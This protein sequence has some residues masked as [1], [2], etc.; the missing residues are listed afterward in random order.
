MSCTMLLKKVIPFV[1]VA[2]FLVACAPVFASTDSIYTQDITEP[3]IGV[4]T[5]SPE[6]TVT[7]L[8][9]ETPTEEAVRTE[10][11]TVGITEVDPDVPVFFGDFYKELPSTGYVNELVIPDTIVIH[12]DDQSGDYPENWSAWRTYNGLGGKRSVHFSVSQDGILQMLPM[13]GYEVMHCRGV[14]PQYT[15]EGIWTDY[16]AHSIQIEMGGRNYDY[17]VTGQASE[18]MAAIVEITTEKTIDLVID[19]M[20]F[21]EIPITNVVGHYQIGRGKTDP[22]SLYFEQYF[23]PLLEEKLLERIEGGL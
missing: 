20:D 18:E 15:D 10:T 3:T 2:L 13:Y 7:V 17:V 11:P 9:R 22:G 19:L 4:S 12:T 5:P 6:T 21:Y 14:L 1:L 16:N 8:V 23:L